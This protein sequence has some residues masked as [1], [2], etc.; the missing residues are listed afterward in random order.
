VNL[1]PRGRPWRRALAWLAFLAPFFYLSYGIA[2]YLASVRAHVPSVVFEWERQLPFWAWTIF[3]YWSINAFYG[4]SLFLCKSPHELDR[5]ALRLLTAQVAAVV[6]FV[7]LPLAFSFGQPPAEGAAG[8]LFAALRGFDKPFNQAPSLH[9]ALAVI[10]WDLYRRLLAGPAVCAVLHVWTFLIC[11][12]VL[13]TYQHHFIDIPTGA[14][15][16]M[17]CV[18]LWPL[19]RRVPPWRAWRFTTDP[20]RR[21]LGAWYGLGAA[22][23][24]TIA[25]SL[26]GVALWLAWIALALLLV[27]LNYFALG[28]RGFS[29]RRNER[30]DWALRCLLAP[31]RLGAWLNSRWWTRGQA[32]AAELGSGVWLGRFPGRESA[33]WA[34]RVELVAELDAPGR[35]PTLRVPALDL[36]APSPVWLLRAAGA[37]EQQRERHGSVL[38]FCALGYSRSAAAAATWLLITGRARRPDEALEMV[39]RARPQVV[40]GEPLRAAVT[41]AAN[42]AGLEG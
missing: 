40:V 25:L 3:P 5:H 6:C 31:Y 34:S 24:L 1:S 39:R 11:A 35:L 26:G 2:N 41:A 22:T 33:P 16:G 37:I 36:V 38:V 32:R 14:A 21:R 4:L 13:T 17:L 28:E 20:Q 15:L 12:S 10:L 8:G 27:A 29:K 7:A 30:T 23:A 18:W 42:K 9:I 19:E